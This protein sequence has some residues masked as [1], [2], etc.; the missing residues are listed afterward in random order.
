VSAR[1]AS[2]VG[3]L[4]ENGI[5]LATSI[6][7]PWVEVFFFFFFLLFLRSARGWPIAA[8]RR[9]LSGHPNARKTSGATADSRHGG[10][11]ATAAV[12]Q[13]RSIGNARAATALAVSRIRHQRQRKAGA[14]PKH[15]HCHGSPRVFAC[16]QRPSPPALLVRCFPTAD[17]IAGRTSR[18]SDDDTA[19][20]KRDG[21]RDFS[22]RPFLRPGTPAGR[23]RARD[24][25]DS[26]RQQDQFGAILLDGE[27]ACKPVEC[28][29]NACFTDPAPRAARRT[30]YRALRRLADSRGKNRETPT[31]QRAGSENETMVGSTR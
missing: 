5:P 1:D 15:Q 12:E 17:K 25:R 22:L 26:D 20:P 8:E 2:D 3:D 7:P 11:P 6:G 24:D 28:R 19:T 29:H 13:A 4:D 21:A 10:G 18:C 16:E 30:R 9:T 27:I 14:I 23:H 31:N